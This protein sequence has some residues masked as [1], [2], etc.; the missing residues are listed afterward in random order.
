M[1]IPR[2][3]AARDSRTAEP[4]KV[5]SSGVTP[6]ASCADSQRATGVGSDTE[7]SGERGAAGHGAGH[8][9]RPN[10]PAEDARQS[11]VVRIDLGEPGRREPA[12]GGELEQPKP[13]ARPGVSQSPTRQRAP[14]Q[15]SAQTSQLAA[16]A[17]QLAAQ[18]RTKSKSISSGVPKPRL[19][20]LEAGRW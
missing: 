17:S 19:P 9:E 13:G 12:R 14:C 11:R 20:P 15:T 2:S 16:Q 18:A 5:N 6:L 1:S 4:G 10:V 7:R 3:A 8:L